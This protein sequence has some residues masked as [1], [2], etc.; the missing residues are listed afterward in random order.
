MAEHQVHEWIDF[1]YSK[2]GSRKFRYLEVMETLTTVSPNNPL[3]ELMVTVHK[4]NLEGLVIYDRDAVFGDS[5]VSFRGRE[6]RPEAWKWKPIQEG[7][8]IVVF[9][10][11]G[12]WSGGK[13]GGRYGKG[14]LK[15][16]PGVV[17]LYQFGSNNEM[18]YICNCGSRFTE[19]Q[20]RHVLN[21]AARGAGIVGV[22][23]IKYE[24]RTFISEGSST[25]ALTA[26]IFLEWH[27]DKS[28]IE[29]FDAR[30]P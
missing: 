18:C 9:D 20:R 13:P 26:P 17:A 11:S 29:A 4:E 21:K 10:P 7:D 28:T 14:R 2:I 16:L 19:D 15:D 25:N 12:V 30:L 1:L 23:R 3:D 27:P 22:A 6:E 5:V 8:F 24:S